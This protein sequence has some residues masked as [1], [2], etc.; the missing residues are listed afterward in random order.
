MAGSLFAYL[1]CLACLLTLICLILCLIPL[2]PFRQQMIQRIGFAR[3]QFG[4]MF[5][6]AG[7]FLTA[8]LIILVLS[9][10]EPDY[11]IERFSHAAMI[12]GLWTIV[13]LT[14][15][16]LAVYSGLNL[17]LPL[18]GW[19]GLI[20]AAALMLA[21][22]PFADFLSLFS[23]LSPLEPFFIGSVLVGGGLGL[24]L[25]LLLYFQTTSSIQNS[26]FS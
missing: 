24:L 5:L 18:I 10:T 12:L 2:R 16:C 8:F 19:L 6:T 26:S 20:G 4:L 17:R 1:V 25:R 11:L 9:L 13:I 22:A 23:P 14:A 7:G 3:V 21:L 15:V